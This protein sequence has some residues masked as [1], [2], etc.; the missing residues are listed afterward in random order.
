MYGH[1]SKQ[2]TLENFRIVF[3]SNRLPILFV[4]INLAW[5]KRGKNFVYLRKFN[6][7]AEFKYFAQSVPK[8]HLAQFWFGIIRTDEV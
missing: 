5:V 3:R 2:P 4:T 8:R 7:V 1:K 6:V